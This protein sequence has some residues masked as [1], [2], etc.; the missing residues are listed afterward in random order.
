MSARKWTAIVDDLAGGPTGF[1]GFTGSTDGKTAVENCCGFCLAGN[2]GALGVCDFFIFRCRLR[3]G[4]PKSIC[5]QAAPGSFDF[6]PSN[7]LLCDRCVRRFAQDDDFARGLKHT[8]HPLPSPK[9][10]AI[11]PF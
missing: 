7:L 8:R 2:P 10:E 5:Q 4:A 3:P 1:A 6:A 9:L 11:P